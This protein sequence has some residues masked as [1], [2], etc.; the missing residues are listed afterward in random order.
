MNKQ[1]MDYALKCDPFV[2]KE[3][4]LAFKELNEW[5]LLIIFKDGRKIVYDR[6]TDYH[7]DVFY[8]DINN[9]TDEQE[10]KEFANRLR[11]MMKRKLIVQEELADSI[12]VTPVMISRYINGQSI[13]DVLKVRKIAKVL[14]CS[15]DDLF[16]P[17][18]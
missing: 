15:M 5:D 13:P 8:D 12:G 11:I 16:Y 4:I 3:D 18:I 7:R 1:Y 14:N 17:Q 10:I 2:H 9:L 6:F